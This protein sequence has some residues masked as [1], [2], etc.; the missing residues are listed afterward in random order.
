MRLARFTFGP[1][2][3]FPAAQSGFESAI[4]HRLMKISLQ[5]LRSLIE[6]DLPL[7]DLLDA[8]TSIGLEVEKASEVDAVPGGLKG[9]VVGEVRECK[10]HPNADRL[11]LT[12]VDIGSS[13][14][15]SIV[16]GAPNVAEGQK[17]LVATVGSV[18]YPMEGTPISIQ[19]SKIRGEVSEGMICAVDELGLGHGHDGIWVLDA[20]A[21][22]G[23]PAA[24]HLGL[25][26]D[27]CIEIGLTPNR[28]D[29]MSHY[30]VA[31]DIHAW[32]THRGHRSRL[33]QPAVGPFEQLAFSSPSDTLQLSVEDAEAC[34]HY[35]GLSM[36]MPHP[37]ETP[38]WIR[39]R[40]ETIAIKP[41]HFLVDAAN[42]VMHEC[43]QPLHVFDRKAI[44]GDAIVVR[45]AFEGARFTTLDGKER[46]LHAQDLTIAN[47]DKPMALAGIFGG[48]ESGVQTDTLDFFIE[49]AWFD[50][51]R[52]R[53][54]ARRHGLNTDASFR[55]ER[56]VDPVLAEYAL[57]RL[58]LLVHE[59]GG[60]LP[61]S[62]LLRLGQPLLT[63]HSVRI[64]PERM[65]RF[66]G[67]QLETD[68]L[69]ALLKGLEIE[70]AEQGAQEW[71]LRVPGYRVDVQREADVAEEVLRIYGLNEVPFPEKLRYNGGSED[72][73]ARWD[74]KKKV[75]LLL[76]G[77]GCTEIMN[78]SLH[79]SSAYA[80][81]TETARIRVANPLSAELDVLRSD[82][83]AGAWEAIRYNLNYRSE[84]LRLFEF[85]KT[86]AVY[87]GKTVETEGLG[88]WLCGA[89]SPEN[90][91]NVPGQADAFELKA[92]VE[93]VLQRLIQQP[94]SSESTEETLV[95]KAGGQKIGRLKAISP[96]EA[97]RFEVDRPAFSVWID[98]GKLCTLALDRPTMAV[99]PPRYPSVRR[100]LALLVDRGLPFAALRQTLLQTESKLLQSVQ[101]F[102][103]YEGERIPSDKSSLAIS[104]VLR[105]DATTLT[106]D[107]IEKIIQKM[108]RAL[109]TQHG[110]VLRQA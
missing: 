76:A 95:W 20:D 27:V 35:V 23:T 31:R 59:Y 2:S 60:A 84:N 36:R 62:K 4:D 93:Q 1:L 43:G 98:W 64:R 55:Y 52:I 26:G 33:V 86:Y 5:W 57:K 90:W 16:C 58:A 73:G 13:E 38:E 21:V 45:N 109:E 41:I 104:V 47:A 89:R 54:T 42:Y 79:R 44:S 19:K 63:H 75:S 53:K 96:D 97:R 71:G 72:L 80:P 49:S 65:L 34:P 3:L 103:V 70:V 51:V 102:D 74:L 32:A 18:L 17:V 83:D 106:D 100:D 22:L 105:D 7:Q 24:V 67:L 94:L 11:R 110:I 56:G 39:K 107:R 61:C 78:N 25:E 8:L 14:L 15:L 99:E 77:L 87:N 85:G 50:P 88:I 6:I 101:L 69:V 28:A 9:V 68:R 40:L 10:P 82:L 46:V 91:R 92:L 81:E 37:V 48:L 12:R 29:A 108:L 66:I 30:G